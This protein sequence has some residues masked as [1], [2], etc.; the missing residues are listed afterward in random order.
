MLR[1]VA[2]L[3]NHRAMRDTT[4]QRGRNSRKDSD[5]LNPSFSIFNSDIPLHIAQVKSIIFV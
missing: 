2:P 1:R 5:I 4:S 3:F